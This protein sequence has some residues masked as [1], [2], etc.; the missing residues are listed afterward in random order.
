MRDGYTSVFKSLED[1][2]DRVPMDLEREQ[3]EPIVNE[4]HR[5]LRA[6][7]FVAN[8]KTLI[9]EHG[10]YIFAEIFIQPNDQMPP[11]IEATRQVRQAILRLNWRLQ[12]IVVEFTDDLHNSD[13]LTREELEIEAS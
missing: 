12:H 1:V 9:R 7:P 5:T 3:Q 10:R 11:A 2:M 6:L 4:V 13:V 8:E